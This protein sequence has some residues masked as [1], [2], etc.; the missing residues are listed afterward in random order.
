MGAPMSV[1]SAILLAAMVSSAECFMPSGPALL[2]RPSPSTLSA[3]SSLSSLGHFT[4]A[5]KS[6]APRHAVSMSAAG[7]LQQA[8]RGTK[9]PVL[10]RAAAAIVAKPPVLVLLAALFTTAGGLPGLLAISLLAEAI[11]FYRSGWF[12][13]IGYGFAHALMG[14]AVLAH[15]SSVATIPKVALLHTC[16][17]IAWGVRLTGFL[18]WREFVGWPDWKKK[19]IAQSGTT[20]V[21]RKVGTWAFV[22]LFNTLLFSPVLFH[23][24]NPTLSPAVANFG[25]GLAWVGLTLESSAD[26]TKSAFKAKRP[27]SFC[28]V[29]LYA[30]CRHPNYLGEMLFWTGSFVAGVTSFKGY[31]QWAVASLG[32]AAILAIMIRG[33]M[34]LD[35]RQM[36]KYQSYDGYK[37]YVSKTPVLLP[38]TDPVD[39]ET[40]RTEAV[41][42]EVVEKKNGVSVE[43]KSDTYTV[44]PLDIKSPY[45]VNKSPWDA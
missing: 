37:E 28:T 3:R 13:T 18:A 24:M 33:T 29:G 21:A 10:A 34:G 1:R 43:K 5:Q 4:Q 17:V 41:A 7:M 23:L 20:P 44:N 40:L 12:F 26:T 42:P 22:A 16:L 8:V 30:L 35:K 15:F 39:F 6:V 9:V 38:F 32:L 2:A 45:T 14:I 27:D 31:V 36:V 25:V 19:M 11:G